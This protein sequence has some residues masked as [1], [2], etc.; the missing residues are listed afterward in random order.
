MEFR[1]GDRVLYYPTGV[2]QNPT[3][4]VIE[5]CI[6]GRQ[7]VGS[8]VVHASKDMPRYVN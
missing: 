6:F 2:E 7:Q 4:G 8:Q 5:K 1:E 3:S